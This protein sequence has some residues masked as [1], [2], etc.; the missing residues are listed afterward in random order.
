MVSNIAV[1]PET[2]MIFF[3]SRSVSRFQILLFS[4]FRILDESYLIFLTKIL[5]LYSRLVSVLDCVDTSFLGT[6][7]KVFTFRIRN[8]FLR[9][10]IRIRIVLKHWYLNK[11]FGWNTKFCR[12]QEG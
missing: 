4:W 1:D 9:T 11:I 5:P 3:K 2:G 10:H 6:L 12:K 7:K 8:D